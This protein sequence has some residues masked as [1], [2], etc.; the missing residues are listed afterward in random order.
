MLDI[1]LST[2]AFSN[3]I[4][5]S[6]PPS[7]TSP[8]IPPPSSSLIKLADFGLSRF[9]EINKTTG[10][11]ELLTTRCGSE[12]YAAP[13]LVTGGRAGYDARKT[14]AWACGVVLYAL[15]G[16]KLPF[17]EGVSVV[18]DGVGRRIGGDKDRQSTGAGLAERRHWLMK[19]ARGEWVWPGEETDAV[20]R[21]TVVDDSELVGLT[22]RKSKGSRRV[23]E[24]LLVR[25]P[26]K[27]AR[28]VDIWEDVWMC[29]G[30]DKIWEEHHP[31]EER[32]PSLFLRQP[33]G[34]GSRNEHFSPP[35]IVRD[36]AFDPSE[37]EHGPVWI[38]GD[39]TDGTLLQRGPMDGEIFDDED[40]ED[41]DGLLLDH[42]GIN[43]ITRQEVV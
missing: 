39:S 13:E 31:R 2:T 24:K 28:I 15:V 1:L 35:V 9:V 16:R 6:S 11:A 21:A 37:H 14:D 27:R 33:S 42:E 3:L 20:D 17:G 38:L 19:I 8:S 25:D 5:E 36:F 32:P 34:E 18:D 29:G 23:V 10:E 30:F 22:L 4:P 40:D 41:E 26:R 12:A 7:P 43:S